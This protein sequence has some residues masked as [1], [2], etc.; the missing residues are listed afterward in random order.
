MNNTIDFKSTCYKRNFLDRVIFR[1]DFLNELSREILQEDKTMKSIM[2]HFPV[3]EKDKVIHEQTLQVKINKEKDDEIFQSRIES[4][5][6]NFT[7]QEKTRSLKFSTKYLVIEIFKY[8]KYVEFISYITDIFD[9][10]EV[11]LSIKR[12]GLRYINIFNFDKVKKF[13]FNKYFNKKILSFEFIDELDNKIKATRALN[14]QEY[15][16]DDNK[17]RFQYGLFNPDY[18]AE[19]KK[20]SFA[21]DFDSYY[22]GLIDNND[23][24]IPKINELHYVAQFMFE[25]TITDKLKEELNKDE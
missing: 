13:N 24:V 8:D 22:Q 18:P 6:K 15:I 20:T 10:L 23:A 14:V 4:V 17:L 5:E 7:N 12:I 19:I 3:M 1:V 9:S 2:K 25:K 21:L 11:E 16:S